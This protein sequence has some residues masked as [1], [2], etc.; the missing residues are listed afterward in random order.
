ME[1]LPLNYSEKNIPIPPEAIYEKQFIEKVV[2]FLERTRWRVFHFLNPNHSNSKETFGF[3][4]S[5]P[6]PVLPELAEF[7]SDMIN[8]VNRVKFLQTWQKLG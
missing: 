8:L 3:K 2:S 6:S 7:E 4:T 5:R 1:T